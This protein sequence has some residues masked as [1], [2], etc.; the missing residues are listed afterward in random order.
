MG[1]GL[2]VQQ[3]E[4]I[5]S[6]LVRAK[7][8]GSGRTWGRKYSTVVYLVL[9]A[10]ATDHSSL[11]THLHFFMKAL[12]LMIQGTGSGVGKSLITAAFCRIFADEGLSVAPFKAQNMALNSAITEGGAE[13]GRAQAL[14]AEAARIA[15][16]A[17]MNPVLLKTAGES[18]SQV[19]I[20]EKFVQQC[21]RANIMRTGTLH[22]VL[23]LRH[24]TGLQEGTT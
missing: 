13:I 21:R 16:T 2:S 17:D 4:S 7:K 24:M 9:L 15:P 3:H 1:N 8:R 12:S 10:A 14:Q 5:G 11:I 6:I 22:G 19:I 20:T 18:G 23:L